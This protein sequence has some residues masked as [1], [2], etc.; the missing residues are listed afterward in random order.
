ML[1]ISFINVGYGDAILIEELR[2]DRRVFAML[3]DGGVP[4]TGAYRASYDRW[5]ARIPAF[6]YLDFRGIDA[7]DA[8]FLSHLHIDHV[9]GLPSVLENCDVGQCW[10]NFILAEPERL[11][12]L[13]ALLL[14]RGSR[15]ERA[16]AVETR[17]SLNL[18][19][20]AQR[21]A[22]T[23]GMSFERLG[24]SPKVVDLSDTL[25]AEFYA[26]NATLAARTVELVTATLSADAALAQK[27]LVQL[28]GIQN[29]AG[30][31]L[32]LSY[33]GRTILLP[34][35]LPAI[36]WR[37]SA[38]IE[39]GQERESLRADILKLAHHGQADSMTKELAARI[40]P[41]HA[42]VSVSEDNPF[43]APSASIFN[44]FDDGLEFW[45]TGTVT[46][47]SRPAGAS[48]RAALP[49]PHRAVV[50]EIQSDGEIRASLDCV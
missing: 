23:R 47:P 4:Y 38:R 15:A 26:A 3:V 29:A 48:Q 2:A 43:G 8:I 19:A 46:I 28:D 50:F 36:H 27:A 6:R 37:S 18:L 12:A 25:T 22:G 24:D 16:T 45:A 49:P 1:R 11:A 44:A 21:L 7:L 34:A 42:V 39:G 13:N 14:E 10:S 17:L 30:V 9:G 31:A 41:K 20:E 32:R 5:P 33:A 35:D 40:A